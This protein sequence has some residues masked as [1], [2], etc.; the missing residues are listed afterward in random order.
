MG[1]NSN[2]FILKTKHFVHILLHF[3]NLHTIL[4][5]LKKK[6]ERHSLGIS[7][8]FHSKERGYMNP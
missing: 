6:C 5:F 3:Q 4:N 7:E 2:A 1:T 8:I